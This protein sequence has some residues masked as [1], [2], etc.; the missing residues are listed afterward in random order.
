MLKTLTIKEVSELT[1][2]GVSNLYKLARQGKI[3]CMRINSK[4]IFTAESIEEW[5]RDQVEN[6]TVYQI[7]ETIE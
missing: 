2:I 6:H 4:Y 7:D 5:L 1:G 3:P